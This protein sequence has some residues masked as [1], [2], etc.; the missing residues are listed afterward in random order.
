MAW[1]V[2]SLALVLVPHLGRVPLWAILGF[3]LLA[4]WRLL[5]AERGRG[6]PSRWM[7]GLV[8]AGL[9]AAVFLRFGTL[10]G[11]DAGVTMLV[12]LAGMKLLETRGSRD[13]Y[14]ALFLGYFLVVT[15]FLYSQS[16]AT[17]LYMLVVT[18]VMTAT[19]VGIAAPPGTLAV[20]PRLRLAAVMLLQATPIAV[21]LFVLVPRLPGPLW[22]LPK[23]AFGATS[24]LDETMSPGN[25][26]QLSLSDEVAFRVT[27]EGGRRPPPSELYW[28]GPVLWTTDGRTW[29]PGAVDRS[30]RPPAIERNGAPVDYVV[31]LEPH[32]RR[33]LFAL[34]LPATVP[35]DALISDDLQVRS[36]RPV[37]ERMLYRMR[38]YPDARDLR[39]G[40]LQR[41]SALEL[42]A[43][44]HPRTRALALQWR[45]ETADERALVE[46]ALAYFR[47]EPFFYT[48]QPPLLEGDTVD[49][50]LFETRRGF[51]E[52]FSAA[53]AVLMR[54]AGIPTRVVT[55]YQGGEY[56]PL[57]DYLIVRSR[58]AHAWAEVWLEGEGW[59][60]IDPTAAVSPSRIEMGV[61]AAIPQRLGRAALALEPSEP[62]QRMWR[63][64]RHAWDAM[65]TSW[66]RWV[67]GY[68]PATQRLLLGRL[69]LDADDY[70]AVG[71]VLVGAI[72]S[73][74]LTIA[75]VG[76]R[77]RRPSDAA[78]A[79][80]DRLC[81]RLARDGLVRA[82][83][84]GPTD[85]AR[86]VARDRPA[87]AEPVAAATRAYVALRYGF[88]GDLATLEREVARAM[89]G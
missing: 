83:S 54:A 27:F 47:D 20:R 13:A 69:G 65:S 57:G 43:G 34:D 53:F 75:L 87:L 45:T 74:M 66:N 82:P 42:P 38:S 26:T 84:E 89:R 35:A 32:Q 86:R 25:I 18:L 9:L 64:L 29:G 23:D 30:P 60:R 81:A 21:L 77:R 68:G 4:G 16:I 48:L 70:L 79:L 28:R 51:C 3:A 6:A 67:L 24:G 76:F 71:A 62:V 39:L 58:D 37:R 63:N 55:G 44:A 52:Y 5:A 59:V 78:R 22:G 33:W 2:G 40:P 56:N 7:V 15:N 31:T 85:F 61:D 73:V 49:A 8:S 14:I 36:V 10:L 72:G 50:F 17:G 80:Y 1:L 12:V 11:R 41:A 19:L 46:R 88:G